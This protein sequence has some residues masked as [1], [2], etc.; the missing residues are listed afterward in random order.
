M[1]KKLL[2]PAALV[3]L[4]ILLSW[5]LPSLA[6]TPGIVNYQGRVVV[7]GTNFD[8]AGQFKF[9]LVDGG[10]WVNFPPLP[11]RLLKYNS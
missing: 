2:L 1:R 8:G 4:S 7:N 11:P 10:T 5:S 9:A 3:P 6:G